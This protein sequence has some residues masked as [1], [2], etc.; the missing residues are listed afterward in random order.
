MDE[1]SFSPEID[2]QVIP[3][4]ERVLT[5]VDHILNHRNPD[6][7]ID[8]AYLED[9]KTNL[10]PAVQEAAMPFAVTTTR[11]EV[12]NNPDT[13]LKTT[14]W[15]GRT[16]V[17][18]AM[19]GYRFHKLP[20]AR[21]R[22][23]VEVDEARYSDE[24]MKPNVA[25]V[26]ISPRMTRNDA[27]LA[28]ARREHLGDED[29]IRVSWFETDNQGEVSHRIMQSLLV[30]DI[31]FEAWVAMLGDENNIFGKAIDVTDDGSALSIMKVHRELELPLDRLKNGP[32]D[33]VA[34]VI[35][36]IA[37][38]QLRK[39]VIE[40]V[41]LFGDDQETM[42]R[43]AEDKADQ[44]LEFELSL[45][46]SLYNNEAN[47][48]TERFIGILQEFWSEEDL[49]VIKHH[50]NSDGGYRMSRELAAVLERA[51]QNTLWSGAASVVDNP[52][53]VNQM[54]LQ[55]VSKIQQNEA[56]IQIARQNGMDYHT[57]EAEN[58]RL[59]A[60]Q[61]ITV[62]G[63][64][65]GN[66]QDIFGKKSPLDSNITL[67][68]EDNENSSESWKWKQG[69]CR[70]KS[71]GKKTEVGPCSVC[72]NCQA[73]FDK[74][75]DPTKRISIEESRPQSTDLKFKEIVASIFEDEVEIE[76]QNIIDNEIEKTKVFSNTK[77]PVTVQ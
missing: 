75:E 4:S 2:R 1:A 19:S 7:S 15:L 42:R 41:K 18:N 52:S 77:E 39:G 25:K 8:Q 32:V 43:V 23:D 63:G 20:A 12:E 17:Q 36:Y 58:N 74:G 55:V 34:A 65:S 50:E 35:P 70:I 26:L 72:R 68:T 28:E 16:A 44:W 24:S 61:N 53:V 54:D 3:F 31:P 45:A 14:K 37:D 60:R 49:A 10:I 47:F 38:P 6:G 71:C 9:I 29:S 33:I 64:C 46:E 66:S 48:E 40:Q 51:K 13:G 67:Q 11:H 62:G 27:R 69:V 73:K 59:I 76:L 56:L 21:A 30:R 22:V 5:E 57:L